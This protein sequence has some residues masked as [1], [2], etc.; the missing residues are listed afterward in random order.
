MR[1]RE[2]TG[3]LPSSAVVSQRRM[4]FRDAKEVFRGR[5]EL[6]A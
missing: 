6:D 5:K 2:E 4:K 3:E 1:E